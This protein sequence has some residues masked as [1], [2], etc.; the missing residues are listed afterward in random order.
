MARTRT[1]AWVR[2]FTYAARGYRKKTH[3]LQ[4]CAAQ[5]PARWC[6]AHRNHRARTC[7]LLLSL[8]TH[9]PA[10]GSRADP[11]YR[12]RHNRRDTVHGLPCLLRAGARCPTCSSGLVRG[13]ARRPADCCTR[14]T[15]YSAVGAA[16]SSGALWLDTA[17]VKRADAHPFRWFVSGAQSAQTCVHQRRVLDK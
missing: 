9:T 3:L 14:R 11:L 6:S 17:F 16:G 10:A 8:S 12:P 1:R 2:V 4:C 13:R 7:A 15:C 5:K